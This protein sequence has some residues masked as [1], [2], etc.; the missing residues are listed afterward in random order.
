MQTNSEKKP[1]EKNG[2]LDIMLDKLEIAGNKLPDPVTLFLIF[3][4]ILVIVSD[5]VAGAGV[6]VVHPST[7]KTVV[8]VSL[9]TKEGLQRILSQVVNN[10]QGFIE[11]LSESL[12]IDVILVNST[13]SVPIR[14]GAR[15]EIPFYRQ[16]SDC[17]ASNDQAFRVLVHEAFDL[18]HFVFVNVHDNSYL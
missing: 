16:C 8:A 2:F 6:S 12:S 17:T 14:V 5:L 15:A 11:L 9:L 7:K 13:A 4:V 18:L 3:C 10:F 1:P